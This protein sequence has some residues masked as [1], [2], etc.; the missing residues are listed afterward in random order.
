MTLI[1]R[2]VRYTRKSDT[3]DN[4]RTSAMKICVD[5]AIFFFIQYH[6]D[7]SRC[8]EPMTD[9]SLA[10]LPSFVKSSI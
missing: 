5:R 3:G 4:R 8:K 10:S 2:S 7:R 6:L 9:T 1:C